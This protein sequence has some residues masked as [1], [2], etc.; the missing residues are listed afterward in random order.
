MVWRGNE[1]AVQFTDVDTLRAYIA[2]LSYTKWRPSN[3]VVHNTAAPTLDQW[4][5]GGVTPAQ[6]MVNLQNYYENQ[7]GWSA[8]P[9]FFIDGKSWWCMTPTNVKGVHSPSWNGTML[10][11][12]HVGDYD[13]ETA[14]TGLGAKVQEMGHQL[15]A[16]CCEFFGWDPARLKFHYEDPNTDHACPGGNMVKSAYIDAVQEYMGEGGDHEPDPPPTPVAR[17][18]TV[19]GVASGDKL[20]IRAAS[21]SSSPII[22]TAENGDVLTVVGEAMNG[23]TRWLRF[24]VGEAEG[25]SVAIYGWCSAQYVRIEA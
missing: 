8:G 15:S 24:R 11:F 4:W 17:Q 25:P 23:S 19:Q 21:S 10:G 12:E 13:T 3:F 20:N 18:G 16:V 7:L 14:S 6:R 2:G 22:G 1:P 5:H 9:H